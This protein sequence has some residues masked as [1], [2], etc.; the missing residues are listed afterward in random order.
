M[1]SGK[2]FA[3]IQFADGRGDTMDSEKYIGQFYCYLRRDYFRWSEY[4]SF[5]RRLD[6]ELG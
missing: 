5:Y 4:I 6:T 3:Q 1:K 2:I